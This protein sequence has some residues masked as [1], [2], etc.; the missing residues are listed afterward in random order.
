MKKITKGIIVAALAL[1]AALGMVSCAD[2]PKD[3]SSTPS[4]AVSSQTEPAT[5]KAGSSS[6]ASGEATP[7]GTKFATMKE[8]A[9]SPEVQK[10]METMADLYKDSGLTFTMTG[11][12]NKLIYTYTYPE[13]VNTSGMADAMDGIADQMA[14]TFE[15]IAETLKNVV[16]VDN[17]VLVVK[18]MDADGTELYSR[19][20]SS[21]P[22][23]QEEL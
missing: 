13:G 11:E 20:F 18:Y 23:S 3:T 9:E 14:P 16:E 22:S 8:Y 5:S 2:S 1:S 15:L 7:A 17:P 12:G 6:A 21:A 19:E 10:Q 4:S